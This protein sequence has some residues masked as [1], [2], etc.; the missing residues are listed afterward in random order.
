MDPAE[1]PVATVLIQRGT[2]KIG[3]VIVAGEAF[4]KVRAMFDDTGKRI[5]KAGPATPVE[6]L[7]LSRCPQAGDA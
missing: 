4:G 5:S 1:G 2:L 7:G 6:V 3:D